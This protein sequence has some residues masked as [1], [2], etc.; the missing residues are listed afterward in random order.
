M[1]ASARRAPPSLS[2]TAN[3]SSH[4]EQDLASFARQCTQSGCQKLLH[5]SYKRLS[6]WGRTWA[7]LH[8]G[9]VF[10]TAAEKC[11]HSLNGNP[12][13][14]VCNSPP[15]RKDSFHRLVLAYNV[16]YR[17]SLEVCVALNCNDAPVMF[18]NEFGPGLLSLS[19]TSSPVSEDVPFPDYT[20]WETYPQWLLALQ[21][22]P[23]P[24]W[25]HKLDRA[26]L[27]G[28]NPRASNLR[29]LLF[30]GMCDAAFNS[31]GFI[32][33]AGG[34]LPKK[35]RPV[36]AKDR[37]PDEPLSDFLSQALADRGA[38]GLRRFQFVPRLELCRYKLI[39]LSTGHSRWLDSMKYA[40]L[41][42]S[43]VVLLV[44]T[45]DKEQRIG[46]VAF[47]ALAA[48]YSPIDRLLLSGM[49]H[50][51]V[52]LNHS[53]SETACY[54]AAAALEA[55]RRD[56][57][58]AHAIARRGENLIREQLSMRSVYDYVDSLFTRLAA[59][60]AGKI[61]VPTFIGYHGGIEIT[62]ESYDN[63]TKRAEDP[64]ILKW[65]LRPPV[66]N[67]TGWLGSVGA[68]AGMEAL[69]NLSTGV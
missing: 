69:Q 31:S 54:T 5:R 19:Y 27:V 3:L 18:P 60:Q 36:N 48:A 11:V 56:D 58:H 63:F 38:V 2:S 53:K 44:S 12:G 55:I 62:H 14:G 41:C 32:D 23:P 65:A 47:Q 61:S 15:D 22:S 17:P 46:E 67:Y 8:D 49:T 28:G 40:L 57:A 26:V 6:A 51:E 66:G 50:I 37:A 13:C 25:H 64:R 39:V 9:R 52:P 43:L 35:G 68:A 30:G 7:C 21:R 20:F 1:H 59:I 10:T 45:A 42:K 33:M 34:S 24:H 29:I 4:L 16:I